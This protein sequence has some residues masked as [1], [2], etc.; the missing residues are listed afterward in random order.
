MNKSSDLIKLEKTATSLQRELQLLFRAALNL[1][2][3]RALTQYSQSKN[4]EFESVFLGDGL[5]WYGEVVCMTTH[6]LEPDQICGIEKK[7]YTDLFD[8]VFMFLTNSQ[9]PEDLGKRYKLIM[10]L[11]DHYKENADAFAI[12]NDSQ[13]ALK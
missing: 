9:P 4:L 1:F 5:Q 6:F 8:T 13:K 7:Y 12:K 3:K 10:K 2:V 11:M